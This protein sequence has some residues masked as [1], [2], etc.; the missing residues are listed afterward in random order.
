[1]KEAIVSESNPFEGVSLMSRKTQESVLAIKV[2]QW[3]KEWD[4][5]KFDKDQLREKPKPYFYLF[6]LSA[7]KLKKLTGIQRRSTKEHPDRSEDRGIQ[8]SL[9]EKRSEAIR[10]YVEYGYPYDTS[11][12][13]R[14][15]TRDYDN[16]KKPG[17]LPTA[18][19]VNI[20]RPSDKRNGKV[21]N[22]DDLIEVVS[23]EEG[24]TKI[25]LPKSWNNSNWQPTELHPIEV[26][27]GQ[28]RLWAFEE[29]GLFEKDWEDY[30]LPVVAFHG[31]DIGWQAYL[32][33]VINI[34]PERI[35][36]SLAYDLYPLLRTE[37]WLEAA[38]ELKV[39]R[40][41]Q[42]QEIVGILY[43]EERSPWHNYINMLKDKDAQG[44]SQA[45]WIRSLMASFFKTRRS[46]KGGQAG[47]FGSKIGSDPF[48]LNWRCPQQAALIALIGNSLKSH[49]EE[50]SDNLDWIIEIAKS[51]KRSKTVMN[52][53]SPSFYGTTSLLNTD[54]GIR[55][56]LHVS[57]DLLCLKAE[58]V[59]LKTLFSSEETSVMTF[60]DSLRK[61][62]ENM[63]LFYLVNALTRSLYSFDWRSSNDETLSA[64]EK[65]RKSAFRGSGG[66]KNI[67]IN[68]LSHIK[69]SSDILREDAS[70]LLEAEM[71]EGEDE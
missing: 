1:M 31:L 53:Q 62:E 11:I 58:E 36:K 47:L 3:N 63:Q 2:R 60:E 28:H 5:V 71:P 30:E 14:N 59:H 34:R 21:V 35:S 66:Y 50:N 37:D 7:K 15:F 27:D 43:T 25:L 26:I 68:L 20:L 46:N 22:E 29:N 38:G 69:E 70:R 55:G 24:S 65:L 49:M 32:F 42:A 4:N 57:N 61:L 10:K 39:Y 8:R 19:V 6:S 48:P 40:E 52:I 64:D 9:S 17:W 12:G 23:N 54:Q 67:R 33:Y 41:T 51:G 18:I 13:T 16:L 56:L 45:S 44:V